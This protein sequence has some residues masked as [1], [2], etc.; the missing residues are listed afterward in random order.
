[1]SCSLIG[2]K[3]VW[4][5][6]KWTSDFNFQ[7]CFLTHVYNR[8]WPIS[9]YSLMIFFW[10]SPSWDHLVP[11]IGVKN[12]WC[13]NFQIKNFWFT[14]YALRNFIS[15]STC[16]HIISKFYLHKMR[17]QRNLFECQMLWNWKNLPIYCIIWICLEL[18]K[19]FESWRSTKEKP[20]ILKI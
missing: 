11:P 19:Y 17:C 9:G 7:F 12:H 14:V 3:Q 6:Q 5:D 4:E 2:P 16:A 18:H 13:Y 8:F 10:N 15:F 20:R 1:M